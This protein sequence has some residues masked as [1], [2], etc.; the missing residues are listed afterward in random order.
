MSLFDL[1][2]EKPHIS[3]ITYGSSFHSFE[4]VFAFLNR[5]LLQN[6][7]RQKKEN[8]N[9]VEF[10][11]WYH[12]QNGEIKNWMNRMWSFILKLQELLGQGAGIRQA[13]NINSLTKFFIPSSHDRHNNK[14]S[15]AGFQMI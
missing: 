14:D 7:N 4:M 8:D 3:Q 13:I 6:T 10:N 12:C 2:H 11:G 5:W 1:T 15:K 9:Y